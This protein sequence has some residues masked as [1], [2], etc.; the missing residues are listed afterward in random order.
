MKT[1]E[2]I[3]AIWV[4]SAAT[5]IVTVMRTGRITP[6]WFLVIPLV[7]ATYVKKEDKKNE[8]D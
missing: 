1:N 3:A 7:G 5:I 2:V 6:L 8:R 4:S